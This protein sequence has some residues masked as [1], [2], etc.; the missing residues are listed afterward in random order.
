MKPKLD[1]IEQAVLAL[2]FLISF[3]EGKSE[4]GGDPRL[5]AP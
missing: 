2:L 5:E 3:T 4:G 1:K